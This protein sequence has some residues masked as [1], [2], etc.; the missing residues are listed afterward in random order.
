MTRYRPQK[1]DRW[2]SVESV[3]D[4]ATREMDDDRA[5]MQDF[6]NYCRRIRPDIFAKMSLEDFKRWN[7]ARL[8]SIKEPPEPVEMSGT[9]L[10]ANKLLVI[11]IRELGGVPDNLIPKL[12]TLKYALV[13]DYEA[14][15]VDNAARLIYNELKAYA[16]SQG[17]RHPNELTPMALKELDRIRKNCAKQ[18]LQP[19]GSTF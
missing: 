17:E 13:E 19:D 7:D 16:I 14:E 2:S 6:Y 12:V 9:L 5:S 8:D 10:M 11:L 1:K 3:I 15:P 4:E 18:K